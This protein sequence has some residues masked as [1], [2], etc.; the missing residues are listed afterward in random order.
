[1]WFN[2]AGK[3]L[4]RSLCKEIKLDTQRI[5]I[6]WNAR[7]PDGRTN[8]FCCDSSTIYL[9][10]NKFCQYV[11]YCNGEFT[12]L[13]ETLDA[14]LFHELCHGLHK[15]QGKNQY[16][17][18]EVVSKLYELPNNDPICNLLNSAWADD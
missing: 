6:L 12:K 18:H 10:A 3:L 17:Q 9:E 16:E 13:P 2:E 15:L 5:T 11:G 7:L 8:L 4:L 14:I 1:M